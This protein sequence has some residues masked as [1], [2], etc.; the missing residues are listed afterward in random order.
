VLRL[1]SQRIAQK[2]N[3]Y[4]HNPPQNLEQLAQEA[5]LALSPF[6]FGPLFHKRENDLIGMSIATY[7][8]W[9]QNELE[10]LLSFIS[11]GSVVL[12]VGAYIGS[13]A[14]AFSSAVGA[15]G[16]VHCI[17]PNKNALNVLWLNAAIAEYSNIQVYPMGAASGRKDMHLITSLGNMG[18]TSMRLHSSDEGCQKAECL[19]LDSMLSSLDALDLIKLDIEGMEAEALK[20]ADGLIEQFEPV[21]YAEINTVAASAD[22]ISWAKDRGYKAWGC[23]HEA[24]SLSN[25]NG[26]EGDIFKGAKECGLLLASSKAI[27]IEPPITPGT[28]LFP[29][30]DID[31]VARILARKPQYMA[32]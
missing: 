30:H 13:H 7:G 9:A 27:D 19:S 21:I 17:E 25:F 10:L 22:L 2:D 31:D 14:R 18:A 15:S 32:P 28:T 24:F 5:C 12:D 11:K 4:I 3:A 1:A 16:S 29:V 6:R 20:G 26:E 8:E 23:L